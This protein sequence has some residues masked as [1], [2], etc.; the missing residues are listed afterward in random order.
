MLIVF[1]TARADAFEP[2]G[3][4]PGSSATVGQLASSGFAHDATFSTACWTAP[5]HGSMF[6]GELPRSAGMAHVGGMTPKSMRAAL[7]EVDDALLPRVLG[8]AGYRTMG[9][10]TNLWVSPDS[11]FDNGFES[12]R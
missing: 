7:T 5:A 11:G 2:Y 4:P 1:D 10:S 3:A 8:K 12:F 9:A 6:S